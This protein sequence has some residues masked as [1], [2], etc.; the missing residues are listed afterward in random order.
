VLYFRE[1]LVGY[2]GQGY[3]TAL[4]EKRF[5]KNRTF[6]L[7]KRKILE[8]KT[9]LFCRTCYSL[10]LLRVLFLNLFIYS[11]LALMIE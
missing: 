11:Q 5:L 9:A 2:N 1:W 6:F 8:V 4:S 10:F 7:I 3:E